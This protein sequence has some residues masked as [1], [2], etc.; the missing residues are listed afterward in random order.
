[1]SKGCCFVRGI[2]SETGYESYKLV[3]EKM[4]DFAKLDS[5][6]ILNGVEFLLKMQ[7]DESVQEE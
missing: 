2:K 7:P 3:L 4:V 6:L 1:M 5:D